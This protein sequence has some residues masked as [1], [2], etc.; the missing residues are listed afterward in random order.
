MSVLHTHSEPQAGLILGSQTQTAIEF[1]YSFPSVTVSTKRN[2]GSKARQGKHQH[3]GDPQETLWKTPTPLQEA[4]CRVKSAGGVN[5]G[6]ERK[7]AR[8]CQTGLYL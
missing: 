7:I 4:S 8:R 3:R 6:R 1:A 5:P 2:H